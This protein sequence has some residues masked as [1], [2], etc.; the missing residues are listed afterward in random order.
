VPALSLDDP[1][2]QHAIEHLLRAAREGRSTEAVRIFFEDSG[3]FHEEEVAAL[4][5]AGAYRLLAPNVPAWCRE[6]AEYG[7]AVDPSVLARVDV[8]VLLLR[9]TRTAG[10]FRDSVRYVADRL[11]DVRVREV[12]GAGHMGPRLA[13]EPVAAELVRFFTSLTARSP[14]R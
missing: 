8:P 3:L 11:T 4:A 1:R 2:P 6:M 5:G 10:W 9:G 7:G 14:S 12:A 13:P